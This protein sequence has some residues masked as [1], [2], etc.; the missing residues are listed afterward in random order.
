MTVC[1]FTLS[2]MGIITSRR[3]KSKLSLTG[4]N[5]AGVSLG[6]A[7]SFFCLDPPAPKTAT[8]PQ[9][10]ASA[11]HKAVNRVRFILLLHGFPT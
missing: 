9:T 6:R 5:W 3:M 7:A 11:S 10:I 1:S 2:R 8:L 4:L